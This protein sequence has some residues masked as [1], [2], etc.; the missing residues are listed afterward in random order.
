MRYL[1]QRIVHNDLQWKQPSKGRR[2]SLTDKGY[3]HVTGFAHE[4]WNFAKAATKGA[5]YGYA[6]F[7]PSDIK[8]SFSIAF[9]TYD[10][11]GQWNLAGYYENAL[12]SEAGAPFSTNLLRGRAE[13]LMSLK[14]SGDL[15]GV[16]RGKSK[17]QI[18]AQ[19]RDDAQ[20]YHWKVRPLSVHSLS[21]AVPIPSSLL[22]K[23]LSRY[24][25]RPTNLT[26][27]Q[28]SALKK[29]TRGL[30]DRTTQDNYDDGGDVEF[31]EGKKFQQVHIKRERSVKLV[32]LAKARFKRE[33]GRLFCE[34]CEFDF[35][36]RYGQPGVDFIEVH[37]TIPVSLLPSGARTKVS[38]LALVCSNCH[39]MLHR[40]RPWRNIHQ[41]RSLIDME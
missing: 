32:K 39:R 25:S 17:Q 7:K 20:S 5:V 14:A 2:G 40:T 36:R 34:V 37:H 31:P 30:K 1:L 27:N 15:G 4:D 26:G 6:Y 11:G 12:F 24:F 33:H 16:Y 23:N 8:D 10:K 35:E 18:V 38:D 41:L 13:Q 3:L 9:A 29:L 22:P 28:F 19:L 21:S